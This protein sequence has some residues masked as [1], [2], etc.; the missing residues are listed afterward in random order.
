VVDVMIYPLLTSGVE[1]AVVRVDDAT[2]RVRMEEMMIQT[3]KMMSV[4]G[5]AAGMAHEINNPLGIIM[6]SVQNVLRRISPDMRKNAEAAAHTGVDLAAIQRYF[7]ERGILEFL[8]DI[9][10]AGKRA[11]TIVTNMLNFSRRTESNTAPV[12][13]GELL[14][15]AVELAASD[16]DLKKKYDFKH[17]EIDYDLDPEL[18]PVP[19][20]ET[21]IEQVLLNL[22]KNAAQAI[23]QQGVGVRSPRIICRTRREGDVARIEIEDNGPGMDE[24]VRRRVFEPFFTT[25]EVGTGTGLG[26]SVS[27]F[28][29][30]DNHKGTMDVESTPGVG[31]KFIIRL[32][33]PEPAVAGS[34]A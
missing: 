28:I 4:G 19:C 20:V 27:Y 9:T 5:L 23:G 31:A 25:K 32:P 14:K 7:A 33:L 10:S 12:D 17:I 6:Q 24:S 16:Y 2:E 11:A 21:K 1:G 3:E 22:F 26:L 13:L 18:P 34:G 30:T 8:A 29:I 15:K